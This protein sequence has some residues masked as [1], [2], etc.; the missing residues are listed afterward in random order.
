MESIDVF[1]HF[2][3]RKYIAA[4]QEA[5]D[6]PLKMFERA[7]QIRAIVDL[8]ARLEILE[9]FP[10]YSQ[11]ISLSSPPI[12]VLAPHKSVELSRLANDELA[13]AVDAGGKWIRGFAASLPLNDVS[14]C[15]HEAQRAI[16]EYGAVGVQ[17]FTSVLGQPLDLPQFQPLFEF[18][19]AR[20]L[21]ILLHPT[22]ARCPY[23]TIQA[24]NSRSSIYGGQS[25]GLMKRPWLL[26]D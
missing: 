16:D 5:S 2:L 9:E 10:G 25:V 15:I 11:I 26:P 21:P 3:P 20:D 1:C 14:A 13:G 6:K 7:Q 18:M 8:K 12:E 23:L 19:A 17:V 22:R 24:K 4:V